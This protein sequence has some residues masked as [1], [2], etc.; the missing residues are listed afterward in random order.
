MQVGEDKQ[1]LFLMP[2][3]AHFDIPTVP[4]ISQRGTAY[5]V[6]EEEVHHAKHHITALWK[7]SMMYGCKKGG[8]TKE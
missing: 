7:G 3:Y 6:P 2:T 1:Y 8:M 5:N 4:T